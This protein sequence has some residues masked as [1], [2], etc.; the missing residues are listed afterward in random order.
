MT[1]FG[2]QFALPAQ[3]L[4]PRRGQLA[5]I[6]RNHGRASSAQDMRSLWALATPALLEISASAELGFWDLIRD[7]GE[8]EYEDWASGLEET[9]GWSADDF[10]APSRGEAMALFSAIFL[11]E[12]GSNADRLLGERCDLPESAWMT[13]ATFRRLVATPPM[14]NL[15]G[16][17]GCGLYLSPG[18]G[19]PGFAPRVLRGEGFEYLEAFNG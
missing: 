5:D 6:I 19:L 10:G 11:L 7:A 18:D 2:F 1:F 9:A 12:P 15:T 4:G 17:K 13:R 14:L 8:T 3:T 16:V